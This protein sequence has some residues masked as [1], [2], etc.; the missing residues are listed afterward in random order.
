MEKCF[1]F[2]EKKRLRRGITDIYACFH[3]NV[4]LDL[5][6]CKPILI[7]SQN[8]FVMLELPG[9]WEPPVSS[10]VAGFGATLGSQNSVSFGD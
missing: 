4:S 2:L 1:V 7:L 6:S 9:A 3:S 8:E 5:E 10:C